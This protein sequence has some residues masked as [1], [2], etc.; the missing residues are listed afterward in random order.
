MPW[1]FYLPLIVR[2]GMFEVVQSDRRVPVKVKAR[3]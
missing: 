1:F 2:M 3:N